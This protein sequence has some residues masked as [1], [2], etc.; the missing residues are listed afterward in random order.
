[1]TNELAI[2]REALEQIG[3]RFEPKH[4]KRM[5]TTQRMALHKAKEALSA[6]S[7]YEERMGSE[8][9]KQRAIEAGLNTYHKIVEPRRY[10]V[11]AAIESA[12]NAIRG[13]GDE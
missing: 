11:E 4:V 13:A 5:N 6:L 1:M 8:K 10:A 12:I 9:L 3:W 7:A 2:V